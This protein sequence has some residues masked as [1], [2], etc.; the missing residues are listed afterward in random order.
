[1]FPGSKITAVGTLVFFNDGG[2]YSRY[3]YNYFAYNVAQGGT[4]GVS[5]DSSVQP[6]S[7]WGID[8]RDGSQFFASGAAGFGPSSIYH[9]PTPAD[10]MLNDLVSLGEIGESSGPM[11]FDTA[12]NLFYAHGYVS[13]GQAKIYR[14]TAAELAAAI[15]NPVLAPL[16][17]VN[18]EWAT[19]PATFTGTDSMIVDA[20][21]NVYV[22]VNNWGV[23]GE[24]LLYR[25][26]AAGSTPVPTALARYSDR[27][28]T[29][30]LRDGKVYMSCSAGIY[31][32]P[33]PLSVSLA[34]E[35]QV[36]AVAGR[37]LSLTVNV[38]GGEGDFSYQW[39]KTDG[40]TA[41]TEIGNDSPTLAI[42]PARDDQGK[43]YYCEVT[44][45]GMTV[46]SP[47][48]TLEVVQ[49]RACGVGIRARGHGDGDMFGCDGVPSEEER[50]SN[51]ALSG[52]EVA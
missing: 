7:L 12:G 45:A 8:T 14:W 11:A 32:M 15:G 16:T 26:T 2:D 13:S 20:A 34:G 44:D 5:Y 6:L 21:G 23:P 43:S 29:L 36:H 19:I 52:T 39:F 3:T 51:A 9:M 30:R 48:C 24:L 4:P 47:P 17:P 27:M 50:V 33:V 37:K 46:T 28:D 1:M 40:G 10:G 49:P 22:T 35:A 31:Q 25:P 18:H 38:T 41:D 42:T